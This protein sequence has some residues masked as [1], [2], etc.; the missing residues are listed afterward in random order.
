T[1]KQ[2]GSSS[3]SD[4]ESKHRLRKRRT[5]K[6]KRLPRDANEADDEKEMGN[7]LEGLS[8]TDAKKPIK[9]SAYLNLI[10]DATHN[11]TDGL[12]MSASFYLSHAA[13]LSTF[14]AVFFHEIPHEL[15][16]FAIL[17]QSGFSRTS[18]LASQFFTALGAITGTI[19]GI[20]IE[21]SSK[22]NSFNFSGLYTADVPVFAPAIDGDQDRSLLALFFGG[23]LGVLPSSVAGVPWSKLVIPF[24]AGG[25]IYVGTVSVL[26]DLLQPDEEEDSDEE[27][28]KGR[29]ALR[30]AS[31]QKTQR[32]ITMA[33]VELGAMLVGLGIMAAIALSEE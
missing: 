31:R 19:A 12:A 25:F 23:I 16:D 20:L 2:S 3:E 21:E 18:A 11:F 22:G 32:G 9:L 24:T 13:G 33:F 26:P 28:S 5:Q 8:R 30:H 14:V 17:V 6:S 10:A 27:L 4:N 15:G 29:A 7:M 1:V